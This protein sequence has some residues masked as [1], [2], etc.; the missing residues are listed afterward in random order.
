VKSFLSGAIVIVVLVAAVLYAVI[1]LG[2]VSLNA[3]ESPSALEKKYGTAALDASTKRHAPNA[4]NPVASTEAN[5]LEGLK[6]YQARCASCHGNP[7][8]PEPKLG[9]SFYPRVPAFLKDAPDMP[10]N[11]NFYI[12]KHGVAWTGMPAWGALLDDDAIWKLTVFLGELDKLPPRVDEEWKKVAVK[13]SKEDEPQP[14]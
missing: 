12:I 2:F 8:D 9:R 14:P 11:E 6:L 4:K 3:D 1:D 5:L 13:G 10:A 7:S